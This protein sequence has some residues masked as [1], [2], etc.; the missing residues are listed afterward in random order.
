MRD[1]DNN[2]VPFPIR[3][4]LPQKPYW[5]FDREEF[6]E[7]LRFMVMRLHVVRGHTSLERQVVRAAHYGDWLFLAKYLEWGFEIT[8]E[9]RKFLIA[10]LRQEV[11]RP[12]SR[13][14]SF[15]TRKREMDVALFVSEQVKHGKK[16]E[17]AI[18]DA[19][20]K[21]DL[22]RRHIQR[23]DVPPFC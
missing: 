1:D 20:E 10:V 15:E 14:A 7:A 6:F 4:A 12:N 5:Q 19:E 22:S 16:K 11:K 3:E 2:I 8:D 9:M 18:E 23:G 17:R 13:P 21:F